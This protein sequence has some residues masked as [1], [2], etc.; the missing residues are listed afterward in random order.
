MNRSWKSFV[1]LTSTV[2]CGCCS[3]KALDPSATAFA[4]SELC[5]LSLSEERSSSMWNTEVVQYGS[6]IKILPLASAKR[7]RKTTNASHGEPFGKNISRVSADRTTNPVSWTS[8]RTAHLTA[9][10][11]HDAQAAALTRVGLVE[12]DA[13][14]RPRGGGSCTRPPSPETRTGSRAARKE[15]RRL[16]FAERLP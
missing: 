12:Q 3:T 4:C 8:Q 14:L 6:T 15:P 5:T 1:V 10:F 2:T 11:G 7:S 9:F 13:A 16:G